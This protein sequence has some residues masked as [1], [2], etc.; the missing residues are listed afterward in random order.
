MFNHNAFYIFCIL[1]FFL[2]P[3]S[4]HFYKKLRYYVAVAQ[5]LK[6]NLSRS[7]IFDALNR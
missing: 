6:C 3:A 7:K 4:G 5:S 2:F 1:R